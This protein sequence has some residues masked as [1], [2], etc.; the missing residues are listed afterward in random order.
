[1]KYRVLLFFLR[2]LMQIKRFLWWAGYGTARLFSI[3]FRK[4]WR[5]LVFVHYKVNYVLKRIGFTGQGS[6]IFKRDNLQLLI[7]ILFL[8]LVIPQT[9]LYNKV[10]PNLFGRKTIAYKLFVADAED[11]SLEEVSVSLTPAVQSA[12]SW[13]EGALSNDYGSG[14]A[15][16]L[17]V[18][19][20]ELGNVVAG[21]MAITKPILISGAA[22]GATTRDKVVNYEVQPGDSLSS[23]AYNFDVSVATVMWA[24]NLSLRSLL[25]LGQ[26]IKIPPTTGVMHT[27]KKGDNLKKI[28]TTYGAKIEDI[29]KFNKLNENGTDL[30]IGE[31]I[32]IPNGIMPQSQVVATVPRSTGTVSRRVVPGSTAG[33]SASGFVWPSGVR[34]ITQY[35]GWSHHGLDIA[36]P[37]HTRNYAAKAGTVA[38]SQCGWNSGYGCYIIIDHGGGVRTLYGHNDE[39]LVSV[40]DRVSAGQTIG[41]MGNTGKVRGRTGIHLHF[42]IQ[43]NG[44]RVNPLGYIR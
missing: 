1:M 35:Y 20:Q 10:D 31:T 28:A 39:L 7:L 40:G 21:G 42:E 32:M 25:K 2:G 11:Y 44:V 26:V 13:R 36:G 34:T 33:A 41:L 43:I 8:I 3:P 38:V 24:N 15:S 19:D 4:V 37:W 16:D 5:A 9:K 22:V 23:I 17:L 30:V 12:P 6:W 14:L 29:T 18:Y 27:I